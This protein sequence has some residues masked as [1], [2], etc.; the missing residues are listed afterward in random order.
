MNQSRAANRRMYFQGLA[1]SYVHGQA[2]IPVELAAGV[3][4]TEKEAEE[5]AHQINADRAQV[6]WGAKKAGR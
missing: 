1:M 4:Q 2:D 3:C 6:A 5:L